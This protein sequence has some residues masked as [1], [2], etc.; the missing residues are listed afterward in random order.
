[1]RIDIVLGDE[2]N[3]RVKIFVNDIVVMDERGATISES[4]RNYDTFQ[5]GITARTDNPYEMW[6]DKISIYVRK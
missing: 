5:A 4:I 2:E 6:I 1:M 3:G